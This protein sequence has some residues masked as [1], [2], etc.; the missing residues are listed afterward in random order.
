MSR[1]LY[2]QLV[3]MV[4]SYALWLYNDATSTNDLALS[5]KNLPELYLLVCSWCRFFELFNKYG[6]TNDGKLKLK[7]PNQLQE[8]L[9]IVRCLLERAKEQHDP[10]EKIFESQHKLEQLKSVLEM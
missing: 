2:D 4:A 7:K 1:K 6:G 3:F 5:R 9:N 10:E 8:V